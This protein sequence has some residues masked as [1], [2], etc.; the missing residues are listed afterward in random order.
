MSCS[1]KRSAP[2]HKPADGRGCRADRCGVCSGLS[3]IKRNATRAGSVR[4]TA[5]T[6]Q[7]MKNLLFN[8]GTAKVVASVKTNARKKPSLWSG[9]KNNPDLRVIF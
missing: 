2:G 8:P 9:K 5:R 3:S 6:M 1:A 4:C 7:S